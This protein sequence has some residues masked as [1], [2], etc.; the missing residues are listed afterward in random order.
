MKAVLGLGTNIGDRLQNLND[1]LA[2]LSRLP[3][4]KI[5]KSSLIYETKPYGYKEQADFLNMAVEIETEFAPQILLGAC[6]GIEAGLGRERQ[7]KNGP[8]IMDIDVLLAENFS[9]D[10]PHLRVPHP[11][12]R[13]RSFVLQ[14]LMDLFP[15]G[16]AYDF[17]FSDAYHSHPMTDIW[18][19]TAE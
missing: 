15:N 11:E 5:L 1:A 4:T 6:L 10:T 13:N 14:P 8:R 16:I 12:I 3:H 18:V 17:S 19:Y 2:A 7:F 9:S